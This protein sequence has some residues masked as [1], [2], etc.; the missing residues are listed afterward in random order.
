MPG[1]FEQ[2]KGLNTSTQNTAP[3]PVKPTQD[4]IV[5]TIAD[6]QKKS[7]PENTKQILDFIK[8]TIDSALHTYTPG[9]QNTFRIKATSYALQSLR[10]YD[11]TKKASPNTFV[12]SNL[13]RLN[14]LR[15]QRQNIIHIPQNQVYM[16]QMLDNKAAQLQNDLGRPPTDQE[17]SQALYISK[18]KLDK[19]RQQSSVTIS[20]AMS[21][22]PQG[23]QMLGK[24]DVTDMDYYNY[25]YSSVSPVDK[26]IMQWTSGYRTKPLSNNQIA[27]KL[28]ISPGAVSQRKNRI[29]QLMSQV[30]GLV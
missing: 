24:S 25:V 16:K 4:D 1:I 3:K 28:H 26:K 5:Q 18:R 23:H 30:R 14:R 10:N 15:R 12:F 19:L 7:T 22:D 6:W 9:Q 27:E 17:L 8:P 21:Q 11:V 2:I 20:Q 13:Q 29:Q